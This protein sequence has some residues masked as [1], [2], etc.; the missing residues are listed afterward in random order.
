MKDGIFI[1]YRREDPGAGENARLIYKEIRSTLGNTTFM[2]VDAIKLGEDFFRQIEESLSSCRIMIVLIGPGWNPP[3]LHSEADFVRFEIAYALSNNIKII[4]VLINRARMPNQSELPE[5]MAA[6]SLRQSLD[7]THEKYE[8]DVAILLE[9][10]IDILSVNRHQKRKSKPFGTDFKNNIIDLKHN[11]VSTFMSR[12][13]TNQKEAYRYL[14]II[15]ISSIAS[16]TFSI[17][18]IYAFEIIFSSKYE[19]FFIILH[20]ICGIIFSITLSLIVDC[21]FE[22][23]KETISR[24]ILSFACGSIMGFFSLITLAIGIL[25]FSAVH[26]LLEL[27]SSRDSAKTPGGIACGIDSQDRNYQTFLHCVSNF[28]SSSQRTCAIV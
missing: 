24:Y 17:L 27:G 11:L 19:T 8:N 28:P 23:E 16:V 4:P 12:D 7:L 18:F 9:S 3:R 15:I 1:S 20:V 5:D 25:A 6:L 21:K 2:D 13:T 22:M 10:V 14:L 26:S